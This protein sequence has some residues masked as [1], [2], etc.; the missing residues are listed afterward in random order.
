MASPTKGK[1]ILSTSDHIGADIDRSPD[2]PI[3]QVKRDR[4]GSFAE[5]KSRKFNLM[6]LKEIEQELLPIRNKNELKSSNTI[7]YPQ[8]IVAKQSHPKTLP[9]IMN[10][11]PLKS[12]NQYMAYR[13]KKVQLVKQREEDK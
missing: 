11:S 5:S 4:L 12:Q 1:K 10:E 2:S 7:K 8:T 6:E 3:R 13:K 9:K